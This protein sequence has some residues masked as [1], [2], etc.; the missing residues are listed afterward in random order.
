M[1]ILD[2]GFISGMIALNVALANAVP[3]LAD[4]EGSVQGNVKGIVDN[5]ISGKGLGAAE[6]LEKKADELGVSI[7]TM[8]FRA[9]II[10][11]IIGIVVAGAGLV[12]SNE[13]DRDEKKTKIMWGVAG[14][15]VAVG[16]TA[17]II[18]LSKVVPGF[19]ATTK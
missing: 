16:A 10:G 9:A 13:R 14:G 4:D 8:V 19:L 2:K 3:V 17:L 12:F 11:I 18:F 6:E 7:Y 1:N 15:A 5:A